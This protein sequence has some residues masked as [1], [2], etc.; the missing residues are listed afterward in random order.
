LGEMGKA[1]S[2]EDQMNRGFRL[3]EKSLIRKE[4]IMSIVLKSCKLKTHLLH[5]FTFIVF[6]ALSVSVSMADLKEGLVGY[7]PMDG[8][9][10]DAIG[11][12]LDGEV[13]GDVKP[14]EDRF[15][16]PNSA[17]N[18][19]GLASSN[20]TISDTAKLQISG[21]MTLAAW[22]IADSK[23][24]DIL[25]GRIISKMAGGGSRSWS[26]NIESGGL[27]A[28]FQIASDGNNVLE[29]ADTTPL[30]T[31][32]WVHI[33]GVFRP[34]K[35]LEVYVNGELK[36]D[37]TANIPKEQFSKNNQPVLIGSRNDCDNCGWLGSIDDVV[38][39]GRDLSQAEIVKLMNNGPTASIE[40]REKLAIAW[41]AIK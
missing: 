4:I 41:G 30:P 25:N 1:Q 40:P 18:F 12:G 24:T 7:W 39:Y 28:T 14:V 29:A 10:K 2:L 16:N 11:N 19:S 15:G 13:K 33:A 3:S 22:V 21:A 36:G 8:D 5:F 38:V 34:G 20:V 26:L 27:P 31:N 32:K 9:G 23:M 6:V 37:N 35:S 17:L